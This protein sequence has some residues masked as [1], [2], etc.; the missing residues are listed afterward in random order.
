MSIFYSFYYSILRTNCKLI[1]PA[2]LVPDMK[3]FFIIDYK[4]I[5][6]ICEQV[7]YINL[8][9]I[10]FLEYPNFIKL[11]LSLHVNIVVTKRNKTLLSN[12]YKILYLKSLITSNFEIKNLL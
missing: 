9:Y 4:R 12:C 8:Q 1:H 3:F 2:K 11:M 5:L 10:G 6:V 7:I